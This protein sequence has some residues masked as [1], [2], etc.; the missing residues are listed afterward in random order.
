MRRALPAVLAATLAC[1]GRGEPESVR[2]RFEYEPGDTLTY[3]YQAS[4]TARVPDSTAPE[5]YSER[6]YKRRARV[7]EVTAEVTPRGDY[8]LAL[9]YR[10]ESDELSRGKELPGE[11]SFRLQITPQGR[12]VD[13]SGIETTKPLFGDIDF[14]S[15][16]EQSQPV[17]PERPMKVGDSWTQEVKVVSPR[18]E[19]VVTTSTYVLESL[20]GSGG[21]PH[22]VIAYEGD[23]YLPV[24]RAVPDTAE[25][26]A[27]GGTVVIEERMRVE[28]KIYFDHERGIVRQVET[29]ARA[30]FSRVSLRDGEPV[31]RDVELR[32]ESTMRLVDAPED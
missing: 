29:R 20:A 12:V 28:G 21:E 2:L 6:T 26:G 32:E 9:T 30:T 14:Q 8:V 13:V 15:Y 1:G 5:G 7:R 23:I 19:P 27:G 10:L 16:F 24:T 25:G 4:G 18:A 31:R 3:L 17:F 22:A 11:I